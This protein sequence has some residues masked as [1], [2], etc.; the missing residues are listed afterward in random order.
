MG[1]LPDGSET[2]V[3]GLKDLVELEIRVNSLLPPGYQNC[4]SEVNP[5]SMG[6]AALKYDSNSRVAWDQIWTHFC[7]LALAGG[8]PHR[9]SLL[10]VSTEQE[11]EA[12]PAGYYLVCE[13]IIRGIRMTTG[14]SAKAGPEH[15]WMTVD[16]QCRDMAAWLLRAVMSE[17]IFARCREGSIQVPAGPTFR[18]AKEVK[19]VV[20]ALAKT[21]HYW[22]DHIPQLQ[23]AAIVE[24]FKEID[25]LQPP[26]RPQA[27]SEG[28][29]YRASAKRIGH[30]LKD[31]I[32]VDAAESR[33][34]GWIGLQLWDERA[35]AWFVRSAIAENIL[36]RREEHILFLPL[37]NPSC[38]DE[39]QFEIVRRMV[40][41]HHLYRISQAE[42][43]AR[44]NHPQLG[45][46]DRYCFLI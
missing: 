25:L 9:G 8:P 18:L 27:I 17:N 10:E 40:G 15:G 11:V 12:E 42:V 28:E 7:D 20:V 14:L 21:C 13:E 3:D 5:R 39:Q 26:S 34:D 19:N 38:S 6:S 45:N 43:G 46:D 4:F 41:L 1:Y 36:A 22:K 16:C 29:W 23:R 44:S 31:A 2:W 30:A 35:A 24:R 37:A 33:Y 32:G